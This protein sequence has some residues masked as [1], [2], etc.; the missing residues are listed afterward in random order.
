MYKSYGN[1]QG[2]AVRVKL[3]DGSEPEGALYN[4]DPETGNCIILQRADECA[5]Q[6]FIA[7]VLLCDSVMYMEEVPGTLDVAAGERARP[8][9]LLG[10]LLQ[11]G[12]RAPGLAP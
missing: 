8:A 6:P 3:R 7:S 9:G 11:R 2:R 4:I 1:L 12:P 5:E 10:E